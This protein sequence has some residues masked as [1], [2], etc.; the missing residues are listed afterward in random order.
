MTFDVRVFDSN[1]AFPCE[2]GETVLD[3]AERAGYSIP[4]C[5]R[6]G[7]CSTCESVLHQG[8]AEVGGEAARGPCGKV[9]LCRARPASDIV[10]APKRIEKRGPVGRRRLKARVYR[11]YRPTPG[12]AVLHRRF[13]AGIRVKFRAGQYLRVIMAD[14]DSRNF[15]M[16][17]PPHHSDGVHLHIR[18]VSGGCFSETVLATLKTADMLDVELPFGEFF[19]REACDRPLVFLATG[20]GFAPISSIIEDLIKRGIERPT[21]LYWGAR[22]RQDVY[23]RTLADTWTLRAGWLSFVPVLSNADPDWQGRNGLVHR[24]VLED[25]P[26]LSSHQV[27]ACGNPLMIEA[28]SADFVALG[29]L[30]DA[31]F[32][33]DPFVASGDAKVMTWRRRTAGRAGRK[34]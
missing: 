18:H 9:L 10:V 21:R 11:L 24:A 15:S 31:E 12:V 23:M 26:D 5:C 14:G 32:Y 29:K 33:T 27:Y 6:K 8:V 2:P 20:T 28:A 17:N 30:P 3:A 34:P 4:Y 19:L 25:T 13:P 22:R 1:I 16:T 7:A